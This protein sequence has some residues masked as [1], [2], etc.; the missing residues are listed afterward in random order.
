MQYISA[1]AHDSTVMKYEA[2]PWRIEVLPGTGYDWEERYHL[3][4]RQRYAEWMMAN[5]PAA[6]DFCSN[7]RRESD[8]DI[9]KAP[10]AAAPWGGNGKRRGQTAPP[11]GMEVRLPSSFVRPDQVLVA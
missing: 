8:G 6:R 11:S 2:A 1:L 5:V 3:W 9:A 7:C 10:C 4:K